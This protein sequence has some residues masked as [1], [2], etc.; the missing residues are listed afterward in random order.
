MIEPQIIMDSPEGWHNSQDWVLKLEQAKAY[1]DLSTVIITPSRGSV[2]ARV[3]RAW[4]SLITPMN[5]LALRMFSV[6]MEVGAAYD[7][8]IEAILKHPQMSKCK[9]IL[10]MEEDNG[11][12]PDGLLKLLESIDD[13]DIIAGLYWLKGEGGKPMAFGVPA[14]GHDNTYPIKLEVDKVIE[15]NGVGMGFTLFKLD[16]FR[17]ERFERPWFKT[18][19]EVNSS[20]NLAF[21]QTQD[22]YFMERA[23]KL[24]YRIAVDT[25]VKVGHFDIQNDRW[26]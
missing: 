12:P 18:V 6:G 2:P 4:F 10:T 20:L 15:C 25:R 17:D 23:R 3:V 22:L 13:F 9:Y 21:R 24:G 14:L 19:N 8:M 26:W 11:P 5:Q 1:R 16:I 7:S